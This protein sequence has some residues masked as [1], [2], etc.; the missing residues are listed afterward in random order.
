MAQLEIQELDNAIKQVKIIGRLDIQ[1]TGEI[2]TSFTA[3]TASKKEK[4][5]VDLSDLNFLSSIGIRL[6][7]TVAKA[8]TKRGGKIVFVNPQSSVEETLVIAGINLLIPIYDN[9]ALATE[10]LNAAVTE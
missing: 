3:H 10:D 8:Q 5:I 2:E 1:G 9:S 6:L 7:L 4:V